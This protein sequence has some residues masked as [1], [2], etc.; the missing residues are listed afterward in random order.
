MGTMRRG[1]GLVVCGS[2]EV[3][4]CVCCHQ[5][6]TRAWPP[7]GIVGRR[8]KIAIFQRTPAGPEK[9]LNCPAPRLLDCPAQPLPPLHCCPPVQKR[10]ILRT[11][12]MY[13]TIQALCRMVD[14]ST[15]RAPGADE[16]GTLVQEC[17][18]LRERVSELVHRREAL[19]NEGRA[20]SARAQKLEAER[21]RLLQELQEA[22]RRILQLELALGQ[23]T[24][25]HSEYVQ[26]SQGSGGAWKCI[27]GVLMV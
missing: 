27:S 13:E 5:M 26:R 17:S 14:S 19:E 11:A 21:V 8:P 9:S 7:W 16:V 4:I 18:T 3:C 15:P 23:Q 22:Q 12:H 25:E 1:G 20:T 24:S 6:M 2:P 10:L